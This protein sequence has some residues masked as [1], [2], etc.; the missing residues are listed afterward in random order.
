MPLTDL[1]SLA[2]AST[3]W[4]AAD[5]KFLLPV[6]ALFGAAV[7]VRQRTGSSH[8]F[9]RTILRRFFK[10][11]S[12]QPGRLDDFLDERDKLMEFR[13]LTGLKS[14]P[15]IAAAERMAQWSRRNDLDID[16]VSRAQGFLDFNGPGLTAKS[17][18]PK[19]VAAIEAAS[20]LIAAIAAFVLFLGA[21]TPAVVRVIASDRH[22]V[23]EPNRAQQ[24]SA[25]LT[26]GNRGFSKRHCSDVDAVA[27]RTGY[28][29]SDVEVLCGLLSDDEGLAAIDE[30]RTAQ[31][32]LIAALATALLVLAWQLHL[33]RTRAQ[34]VLDLRTRMTE[35]LVARGE[36][37]LARTASLALHARSSQ[38]LKPEDLTKATSCRPDQTR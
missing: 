38:R 4:L 19:A 35:A 15:T 8:V 6:F 16:L 33:L 10:S 7:W 5:W 2:T 1:S 24:L 17:P 37:F 9:G 11:R 26:G 20:V 23:V 30:A 14:A 27:S 13:F 21:L 31:L 36:A 25:F 18:G 3:T 28:V 12:T 34:A 29:K 22:Y 32:W